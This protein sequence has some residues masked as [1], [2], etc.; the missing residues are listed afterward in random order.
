MTSS[1]KVMGNL[2]Y[3]ATLIAGEQKWNKAILMQSQKGACSNVWTFSYAPIP[4]HK[5]K[6]KR[7][8]FSGKG[9]EFSLQT[10]ADS[11]MKSETCQTFPTAP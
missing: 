4:L 5:K 3:T 6:K 2:H 9:T 1:R 11:N 8:A 10:H 7:T